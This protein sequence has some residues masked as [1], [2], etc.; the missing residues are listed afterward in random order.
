MEAKIIWTGEMS[1]YLREPPQKVRIVN[2]GTKLIAEQFHSVSAIGVE[3]WVPCNPWGQ[4]RIVRHM[5][6]KKLREMSNGLTLDD[7][8]LARYDQPKEE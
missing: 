8:S 2:T 5:G 4:G 1:I 6:H 3:A 7:A